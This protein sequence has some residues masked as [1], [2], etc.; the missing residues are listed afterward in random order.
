MITCHTKLI[1]DKLVRIADWT[2]LFIQIECNWYTKRPLVV[3]MHQN[4]G[5]CTH[6]EQGWRNCFSR[7][8]MATGPRMVTT[9]DTSASTGD[10]AQNA[11][12]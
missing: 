5:E 6:R 3:M 1:Q 10:A 12:G 2:L 9:V 8:K 4:R 11:N 7:S